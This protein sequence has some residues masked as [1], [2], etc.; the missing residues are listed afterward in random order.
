MYSGGD[1]QKKTKRKGNWSRLGGV[2]EKKG[3]RCGK[4]TKTKVEGGRRDRASGARK[5]VENLDP[6][7]C[8][9]R[10]LVLSSEKKALLTDSL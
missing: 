7:F 5:K 9:D 4:E 6:A 8:H 2:I 10:Q 1:E 3:Q